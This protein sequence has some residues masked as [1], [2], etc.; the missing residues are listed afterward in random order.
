MWNKKASSKK[1]ELASIFYR[2]FRQAQPPWD[3]LFY[4]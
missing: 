3:N 1:S 4:K 2:W